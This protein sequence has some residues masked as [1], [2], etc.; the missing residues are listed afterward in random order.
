MINISFIS[1]VP[2]ELG[3]DIILYVADNQI[4]GKYPS[5]TWTLLPL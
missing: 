3:S 5:V 4:L 1:S 2:I